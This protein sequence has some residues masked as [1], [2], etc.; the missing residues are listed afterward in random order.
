MTVTGGHPV[1]AGRGPD[2]RPRRAGR[3]PPRRARRLRLG[4]PILAGGPAAVFSWLVWPDATEPVLVLV[5][6]GPAAPVQVGSVRLTELAEVPAAPVIAP[7]DPDRRRVL[8]LRPG[9][10]ARPGPLRRRGR[11]AGPVD[12]LATGPQ[13][14]AVPGASA[15]RRRS[16]CPRGSPIGRGGGRS[17]A[18]PTRTPSAPI[19][20]TCCSAS[21]AARG[22]RPGWSRRSTGPCPACPPPDS[23]EALARGLVRV[24][25]RGQADGPR[26]SPAPS[27][28]AA[29]P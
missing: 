6:R 21:W 24:D 10:P 22:A 26:L 15:A 2:G 12:L 25:R 20:S 9:G 19:A 7:P 18:R 8:G 14:R 4:A 23:P 3:P 29:R 17:T 28:G 11:A 5:N 27:R 13:P 1:G 16:S